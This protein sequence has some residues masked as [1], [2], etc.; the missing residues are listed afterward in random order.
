MVANPM[1]DRQNRVGKKSLRMIGSFNR[2]EIVGP[3]RI[4]RCWVVQPCLATVCMDV[5]SRLHVAAQP[6]NAILTC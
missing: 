5:I 3:L 1:C 6:C 2:Q 4:V